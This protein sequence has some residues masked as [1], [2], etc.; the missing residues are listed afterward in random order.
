MA[1]IKPNRRCGNTTRQV[2]GWIQELFES[3]KVYVVDH[4]GT[5]GGQWYAEKIM[6]D[7]LGSEHDLEIGNPLKYDRNTCLL[8]FED[9]E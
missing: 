2:D 7:R 9:E 1:L 8:S 4:S 5:K 6:F 3:G